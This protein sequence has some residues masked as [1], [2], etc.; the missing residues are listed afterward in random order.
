MSKR[1]VRQECER[2][3]SRVRV[4]VRGTR[5]ARENEECKR[6]ARGVRASEECEKSVRG[7]RASK[8]CEGSVRGV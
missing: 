5:D 8:E 1:G 3:A 7:A 6:S 4:R 2:R